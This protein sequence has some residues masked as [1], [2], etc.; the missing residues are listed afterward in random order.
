V[1]WV[2][3]ILVARLIGL[4]EAKLAQHSAS[5]RQIGWPN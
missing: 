3:G 2:V 1:K 4:G 5:A